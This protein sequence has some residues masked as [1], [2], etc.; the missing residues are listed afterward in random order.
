M[1]KRIAISSEVVADVVTSARRRCCICYALRNDKGE[2]KGQIAHLDHNSQNNAIDNLAFLC[3]E[4]HDVYDSTSSQSKGLTVK[5]VKRYR[6][7]LYSLITSGGLEDGYSAPP[8]EVAAQVTDTGSVLKRHTYIVY[9]TGISTVTVIPIPVWAFFA[10]RGD[11]WAE[12]KAKAHLRSF[13]PRSPDEYLLSMGL[14][15]DKGGSLMRLLGKGFVIKSGFG[16]PSREIYNKMIDDYGYTTLESSG[17][18]AET[19]SQH[20]AESGG[21]RFAARL[22]VG[23]GLPW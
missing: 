9:V 4:H 18:T 12:F 8:K 19:T 23:L 11:A 15:Q 21:R 2:K 14:T 10:I 3:L 16:Y 17:S 6:T 20:E 5:E 22:R 7:E 13:D 1:S